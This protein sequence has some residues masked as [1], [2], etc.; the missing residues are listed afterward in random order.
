[1]FA[2]ALAALT[3]IALLASCKNDLLSG[4]CDKTADCP[5]GQTCNLEKTAAGNGR[6]VPRGTDGGV[7]LADGDA[8]AMDADAMDAGDADG[9][10]ADDDGGGE[11]PDADGSTD[12]VEVTPSCT[13]SS[14]GAGAPIC[15]ETSKTCRACTGGMECAVLGT[16]APACVGGRC[17]ECAASADC[18]VTTK[19]ICSTATNVCKACGTGAECAARAA[20]KPVCDAS[21]ACVECVASSDCKTAAAPICDAATHACVKCAAD[22]QC[23]AR[24]AAAPACAPGGT[25]VVC[26]DGKKHCPAAAP[27]CEASACQTCKKDAECVA[28]YGA[29][30]GLCVEGKCATSG[31]VIYLQ[32]ADTCS[33]TARGD[34]S[35]AT[36]F[37]YT[38]DASAALSNQKTIL[39]IRGPRPLIEPLA[40]G[41]TGPAVVVVGQAGANFGTVPGTT[42]LVT[43]AAGDVTLRDLDIS[44]GPGLGVSVTGGTVHMTRCK[45]RNNATGGISTQSAAFDITNTVIAGNMGA[46]AVSL[47]TYAGAGPKRFA[48]NTVVNNAGTGVFCGQAYSMTGLLVNGNVAAN[49]VA[50]CMSDATSSTMAPMFEAARPFHLTGSS[51]CV[52]LGGT[53]NLP[54]DDL[55]GDA[56]PQGAAAD[57]GA[58]EYV[59]P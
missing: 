59:V 50:P 43:V 18:G 26:T 32:N 25:C 41:T 55:D 11:M 44:G 39:L 37:C 52:N 14:C 56:R 7:D 2:R 10:G 9:M 12:K 57:C 8:D 51:P 22:A 28:G 29:D 48:F 19:P 15:D 42:P 31:N 49:I 27:I 17:V 45:V 33:S 34:G 36:P 58:D 13:A 1:M 23:Q 6:C 3:A 54:P 16:S 4:R 35:V 40:V 30:P 5:S 20:G 46:A 24:G 21:G 47:G 53:A 38:S